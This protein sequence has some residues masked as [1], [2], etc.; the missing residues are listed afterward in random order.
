M[1]TSKLCPTQGF[2]PLQ[3]VLGRLPSLFHS[4]P[5]PL[6]CFF[7]TLPGSYSVSSRKPDMHQSGLTIFSL[8][9]QLRAQTWD[10][11]WNVWSVLRIDVHVPQLHIRS[12]S[13]TV[14]CSDCRDSS[15][16]TLWINQISYRIALHAFKAAKLPKSWK[17]NW[18]LTPHPRKNT[19]NLNVDYPPNPRCTLQNRK[20]LLGNI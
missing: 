7:F 6:H 5:P 9:T 3:H 1:G 18:R 16:R 12:T 20:N 10:P 4:N 14:V 17:E 2:Q 8:S 15:R 19:C 13:S 11:L